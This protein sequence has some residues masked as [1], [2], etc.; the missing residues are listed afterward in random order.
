MF[1][2]E[3][4][5]ELWLHQQGRGW[6]VDSEWL[7]SG[8]TSQGQSWYELYISTSTGWQRENTTS[9]SVRQK[10]SINSLS[11]IQIHAHIGHYLLLSSHF[12]DPHSA[13][14]HTHYATHKVVGVSR[15]SDSTVALAVYE[16]EHKS[17]SQLGTASQEEMFQHVPWHGGSVIH[18]HSF[19]V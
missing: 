15:R 17:P 16:H 18:H 6:E 14:K 4:L 7:T 5:L 8:C 12:T 10:K 11:L 3:H 2:R 19:H 13:H 1:A 9:V